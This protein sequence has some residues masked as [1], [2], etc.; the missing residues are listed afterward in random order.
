MKQDEDGRI[1]F[2]FIALGEVIRLVKNAALGSGSIDA[3]FSKEK[4]AF[5]GTFYLH[6]TQLNNGTKLQTCF[7]WCP[8]NENNFGWECMAHGIRESGLSDIF[9]RSDMNYILFSDGHPSCHS[10]IG[11]FHS[12]LTQEEIKSSLTGNS[13]D[14]GAPTHSEYGAS[15]YGALLGRCGIHLVA[16]LKSDHCANASEKKFMS[17]GAHGKKSA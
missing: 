11:S 2:L 5:R 13:I 1:L 8:E 16:V 14:V 17:G 12:S 9:F 15:E 10:F 7:G 3:A 6:V 4:E